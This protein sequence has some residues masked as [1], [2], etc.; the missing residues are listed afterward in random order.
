MFIDGKWIGN[1]FEYPITYFD[2]FKSSNQ[3]LI[4]PIQAP[5]I[6]MDETHKLFQNKE[7]QDQPH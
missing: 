7:E 1:D 6:I 2:F 5:V 4:S 3:I